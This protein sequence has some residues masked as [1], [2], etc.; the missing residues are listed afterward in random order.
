MSFSS[1]HSSAFS[2]GVRPSE[3]VEKSSRPLSGSSVRRP[4]RLAVVGAAALDGFQGTGRGTGWCGRG[5]WSR[6][7]LVRILLPADRRQ[8]DWMASGRLAEARLAPVGGAA[9]LD[10]PLP[11]LAPVR[12]GPLRFR[13]DRPDPPR[14]GVPRSPAFLLDCFPLASL[15]LASLIDQWLFK[16]IFGIV[17]WIVQHRNAYRAVRFTR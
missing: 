5:A 11:R 16:G 14:C 3:S 6:Q 2:S 15:P 13:G 8:M 12:S 17:K 4:V 1:C 10:R 9:I 7:G